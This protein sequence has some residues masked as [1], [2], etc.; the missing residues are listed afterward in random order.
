MTHHAHDRGRLLVAAVLAA[1]LVSRIAVAGNLPGMQF[2]WGENVGWINF[3]PNQGPGVTLTNFALT[4]F[5]WG[6]NIGWINLNPVTGGVMND[7]FGH[8]SG[9]AWGENVGWIN[10][11]G[12]FI[13]TTGH[14]RGFAWGENVGFITFDVPTNDSTG[15]RPLS[16]PMLSVGGIL[17][18]M[19]LL[20]LTGACSV[21]RG[22][23][24]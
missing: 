24:A 20:G 3:T 9:F 17:L 18:A 12:V 11:S 13:D 15:F 10:F 19:L 6:E 16:V 22:R 23:L 2:A 21:K 1:L 4:G 14:L 7:G 5:A 8:L